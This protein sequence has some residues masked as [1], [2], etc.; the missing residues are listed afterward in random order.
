[1]ALGWTITLV[2]VFAII[3]ITLGVI[4]VWAGHRKAGDVTIDCIIALAVWLLLTTILFFATG[5]I[6]GGV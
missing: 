5:D 3:G 6:K 2:V 4:W 1:M